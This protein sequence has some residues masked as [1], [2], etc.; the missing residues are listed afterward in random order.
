MWLIESTDRLYY[1]GDSFGPVQKAV[2]FNA[3]EDLP[4]MIKNNYGVVLF[5]QV[6]NEDMPIV[7]YHNFSEGVCAVAVPDNNLTMVLDNCGVKCPNC[8]D[9]MML[10]QLGSKAMRFCLCEYCEEV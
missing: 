10:Y 6:V 7:C 2:A 8:D 3:V 1:D 4:L 9:D 5:V